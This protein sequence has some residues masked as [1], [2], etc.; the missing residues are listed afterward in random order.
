M[1]GRAGRTGCTTSSS[2]TARS[3]GRLT[4]GQHLEP[5]A[6][7]H[8]FKLAHRRESVAPA[9]SQGRA[10]KGPAAG[11]SRAAHQRAFQPVGPQSPAQP[12]R[13][14]RCQRAFGQ[15]RHLQPG[16][17]AIHLDDPEHSGPSLASLL[18]NVLVAGPDT[19]ATVPLCD[20]LW[21]VPATTEVGLY[22]NLLGRQPLSRAL[23]NPGRCGRSLTRRRP[24]VGAAAVATTGGGGAGFCAAARR[25][26]PAVR[27]AVDARIVESVRT[28]GGAI[29]DSPAE[30]GGAAQRADTDS[31]P[32]LPADPA[33][34]DDGDGYTNLEEWLHGLAAAVEGALGLD[35]DRGQKASAAVSTRSEG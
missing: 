8:L 1:A 21:D 28:H 18:G 31:S 33:G 5:G 6:R 34:D 9:A 32:A 26:T 3:P 4:R 24:G 14:G 13:K 27:D 7:C 15:Q 12:D 25:A 22:D 10:L 23:F 30:V 20:V 2:I 17:E 19:N 11:R 16:A 35:L 29:I